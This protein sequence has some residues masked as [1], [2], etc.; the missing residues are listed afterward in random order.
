MQQHPDIVLGLHT[1]VDSPTPECQAALARLKTAIEASSLL[2]CFLSF[3]F[4]FL[5]LT[6]DKR[7]VHLE[8]G[9]C[10]VVDNRKAL[11]GRSPFHADFDGQDRWLQRVHI[12]QHGSLWN[13][14]TSASFPSRV[15]NGYFV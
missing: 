11:H 10:I 1:Q 3:F 6:Q 13:Q 9:D 12:R 8:P 5:N 15:F 7:G 14:N 4:F 2:P